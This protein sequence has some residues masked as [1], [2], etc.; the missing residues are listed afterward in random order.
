MNRPYGKKHI[1]QLMDTV[2]ATIP[3]AALRTTMMVGFPGE[4][5]GDIV[6]MADFLQEHHF[7]HLGVFAYANEEGCKA[8]SFPGQIPEEAK[9]ERL[10][11]IMELHFL[12][13]TAETCWQGGTGPGGRR[14]QRI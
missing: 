10:R 3:G 2:R 8:A 5:E 9:E 1:I 7:E 13:S 11:K 14:K 12:C 4:T 6:E